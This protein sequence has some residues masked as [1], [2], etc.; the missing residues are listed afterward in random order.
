MSCSLHT[1]L[2]VPPHVT[3]AQR[4]ELV[5]RRLDHVAARRLATERRQRVVNVTRHRSPPAAPVASAGPP[6]PHPCTPRRTAR[7]G[8]SALGPLRASG[9]RP[10]RSTR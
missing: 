5:V 7:P 9:P 1:H 3:E 10:R 2:E 8:P 6:P 4:T